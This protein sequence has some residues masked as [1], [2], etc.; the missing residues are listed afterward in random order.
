MVSSLIVTAGIAVPAWFMKYFQVEC[1]DKRYSMHSK[2]A[3]KSEKSLQYMGIGSGAI[4]KT[5]SGKVS[6]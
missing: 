5:L 2:S 6:L 1:S 4:N 3:C